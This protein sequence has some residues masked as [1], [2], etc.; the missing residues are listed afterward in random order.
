META[1]AK[2][3]QQETASYIN[4]ID[5]AASTENKVKVANAVNAAASLNGH[6]GEVL[7][8]SDVI[9]M[10]GVRRGRNGA[11]DAECTN[12]YLVCETGEVFFTQS[13]G[14]ARSVNFIVALFPDCNAGNGYIPVVCK[15]QQM[16]NGNSLK[17]LEIVDE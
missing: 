12:V 1:I 8:V 9:T 14:V 5:L 10:P 6:E 7:H 17:T 4:T 3:N 16:P 13:S 11:P 2:T 15:E